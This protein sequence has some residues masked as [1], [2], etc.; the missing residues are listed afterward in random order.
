[1]ATASRRNGTIRRIG[2]GIIAIAAVLVTVLAAPPAPEAVDTNDFEDQITVALEDYEGNNALAEGAPQQ[3]VVNGWVARDLLTVISKQTNALLGSSQAS[4]GDPRIPVLLMLLVLAVAWHGLTA[5]T[6]GEVAS[7][8]GSAGSGS[9]ASTAAGI[10]Q[11]LLHDDTTSTA[12]DLNSGSG[13]ADS[14]RD[15]V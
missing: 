2:L 8:P 11:R 10:E 7:A 13:S 14:G 6:A 4:S 5:P 15:T 12:H 3:E 9:G 1:M